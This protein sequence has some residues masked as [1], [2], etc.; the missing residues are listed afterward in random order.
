MPPT[1]GA[2]MLKETRNLLREAIALT[3]CVEWSSGAVGAEKDGRSLEARGVNPDPRYLTIP[4]P[5]PNFAGDPLKPQA[6]QP[7]GV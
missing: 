1:L 7:Q 3:N 5:T 2:P 4:A 6:S